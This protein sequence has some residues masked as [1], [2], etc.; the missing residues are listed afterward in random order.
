[1]KLVPLP[2]LASTL[3]IAA[4]GDTAATD[5]L[6]PASLRAQQ[7]HAALPFRGSC[8]VDIVAFIPLQFGGG[9]ELLSAR[10][11]ITGTCTLA[12]MGRT[13]VELDQITDYTVFPSYSTS[14]HTYTAANG[15]VVHADGVMTAGAPDASGNVAFAGSLIVTGGTGR[16]AAAA[17]S[18]S[19]AGAFSLSAMKGHYSLIGEISFTAATSAGH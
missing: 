7:A 14:T 17:G 10:Q 13:A 6:S 4:C 19:A 8:D 16:F 9:G 11:I 2:M 1:M 15:D 3:L 5:I 18:S 12:H